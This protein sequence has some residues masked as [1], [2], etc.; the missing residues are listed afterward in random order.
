MP[1]GAG[2][3][4]TPRGT[5]VHDAVE[6]VF[7][8][9][10]RTHLDHRRALMSRQQC[11]SAQ[12]R[13]ANL[14]AELGRPQPTFTASQLTMLQP[15]LADRDHLITPLSRTDSAAAERLTDACLAYRRVTTPAPPGSIE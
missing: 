15:L 14:R 12:A 1:Q 6:Q 10:W 8:M 7:T 9:A 13:R 2:L 3:V 11:S 5:G 4:F